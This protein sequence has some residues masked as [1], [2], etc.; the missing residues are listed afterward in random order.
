MD[1]VADA[2]EI[3][4]QKDHP[5]INSN[6]DMDKPKSTE[7][8]KR[9]MQYARDNKLLMAGMHLPPPGFAE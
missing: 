3:A 6:Y 9:V 7:S 2:D 4:L 5:E 8:R 1:E